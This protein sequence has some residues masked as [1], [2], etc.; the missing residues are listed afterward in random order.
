MPPPWPNLLLLISLRIDIH[1]YIYLSPPRL[2][3][4]GLAGVISLLLERGRGVDLET[5]VLLLSLI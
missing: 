4:N 1:M 5:K 2:L 3:L